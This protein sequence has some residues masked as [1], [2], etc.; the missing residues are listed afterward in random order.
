MFLLQDILV[1]F[2]VVKVGGQTLPWVKFYTFCLSCADTAG[3][4]GSKR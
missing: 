1:S 2:E 4:A 3:L